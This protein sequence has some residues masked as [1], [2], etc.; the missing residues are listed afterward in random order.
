M[1]PS[2]SSTGVEVVGLKDLLR[3]LRQFGERDAAREVRSEL[4]RAVIPVSADAKRRSPRSNRNRRRWK[5]KRHLADTVRP[6]VRGNTVGIRSPA[7][8]AKIVH[9][10]GRRPTG[11]N[12]ERWVSVKARPFISDAVED[13]ADR[14]VDDLWDALDTAARRNGWR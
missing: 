4:R 6:F 1:P 3:D 11:A 7:P 2:R 10:G 12:R 14:I 5:Y 8:H 13:A 9:W